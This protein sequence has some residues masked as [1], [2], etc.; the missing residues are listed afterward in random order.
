MRP[1]KFRA[2][3]KRRRRMVSV[4]LINFKSRIIQEV[5]PYAVNIKLYF[6]Q[7]KLM[8]STGVLDKNGVEIY[9]GD[10]VKFSARSHYH[11]EVYAWEYET[12]GVG[13]IRYEMGGYVLGGREETHILESLFGILMNYEEI[14]TEVIGNIYENEESI[15]LAKSRNIRP[16]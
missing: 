3:D 9:E 14:E 4:E 1:I 13:I 5:T 2:W 15:K 7:V 11:P 8:Q 16:F 12:K 6:D 10:I